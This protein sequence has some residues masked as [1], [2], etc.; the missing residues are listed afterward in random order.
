MIADAYI[1]KGTTIAVPQYSII[2]GEIN[3]S[4][5]NEKKNY[6]TLTCF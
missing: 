2:R 6:Q 3:F 5:Q 1:P 4:T